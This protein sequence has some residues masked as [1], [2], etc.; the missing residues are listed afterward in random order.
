MK[1]SSSQQEDSITIT[2][3]SSTSSTTP[4]APSSGESTSIPPLLTLK[5]LHQLSSDRLVAL[6]KELDGLQTLISTS[7]VGMDLQ[8]TSIH[9]AKVLEIRSQ[10]SIQQLFQLLQT[11][12]QLIFASTLSLVIA[13]TRS[14]ETIQQLKWVVDKLLSPLIPSPE[15]LNNPPLASDQMPKDS[16]N[17]LIAIQAFE[18]NMKSLR[19]PVQTY[20]YSREASQTSIQTL[21]ES[22]TS[23][24]MSVETLMNSMYSLSVLIVSFMRSLILLRI[25]T[26]V[27]GPKP[28]DF[29]KLPF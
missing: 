2:P 7:K 20:I 22:T 9:S 23:L 17:L 5:L 24:K 28:R 29:I 4:A 25:S 16:M 19:T 26:L 8:Q 12:V 27:F 1:R 3:L 21:E 11:D 15:N 18:N 6:Q 10:A 14:L 13:T